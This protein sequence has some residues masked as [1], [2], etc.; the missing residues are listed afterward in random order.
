MESLENRIEELDTIKETIVQTTGETIAN[1]G[2]LKRMVLLKSGDSIGTAFAIELNE[3][4][5]LITAKHLLPTLKDS[6]NNGGIEQYVQ[7]FEGDELM[8]TIQPDIG[9][10]EK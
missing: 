8:N 1:R 6:R 7:I 9:A 3:T 2:L 5:Y 10:D 4:K